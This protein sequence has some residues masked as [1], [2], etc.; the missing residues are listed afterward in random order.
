MRPARDAS[1]RGER[2]AS[3]P[4][5]CLGLRDDAVDGLNELL[6][7]RQ[8]AQAPVVGD[9]LAQLLDCRCL[10]HGASVGASRDARI[11]LH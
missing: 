8:T 5:L 7:W 11:D 2:A 3:A 4:Q 10:P 1:V 6:V 9:R